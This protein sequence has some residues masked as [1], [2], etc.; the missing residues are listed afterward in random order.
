[1]DG[2]DG[3]DKYR[4][5]RRST[6]PPPRGIEADTSEGLQALDLAVLGMHAGAVAVSDVSTR[7][8]FK[9]KYPE[10]GDP[11]FLVQNLTCW[12]ELGEWVC[13]RGW[14]DESMCCDSG[15]VS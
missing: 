2:R 1:M 14:C 4:A 6:L 5:T 11:L 13:A 12:D 8:G 10:A 15:R 7:T 3:D 9:P